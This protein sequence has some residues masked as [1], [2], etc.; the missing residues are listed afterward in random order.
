[1]PLPSSTERERGRMRY[2]RVKVE[3][4]NRKGHWLKEAQGSEWE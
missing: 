4:N 1:M 3:P 2:L